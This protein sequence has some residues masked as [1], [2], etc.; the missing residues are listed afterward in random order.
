MACGLLLAI[1]FAGAAEGIG[2]SSS[3]CRPV[4]S[5]TL[6]RDAH[7][8]IY[9]L[10]TRGQEAE[11]SPE[12][13]RVFGCLL[14]PGRS[15]LLGTTVAGF[16]NGSAGQINTETIAVAAPFAAYSTSSVGIDFNVASVKVRNLRTGA[17][18]TVHYPVPAFTVEQVSSISDIVVTPSGTVGWIGEGR[19]VAG[20]APDAAVGLAGLGQSATILEEGPGI[21]PKSLQLEGSRLT[22]LNEG[23]LHSAE[24]P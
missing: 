14:G 2:V 15:F 17:A 22:W 16:R 21:D 11:R 18:Y 24:M 4:G 8:R 3:K 1:S 13:V 6:I 12:S 9:T 23:V 19:F 20:G 10:P 7:T 5:K